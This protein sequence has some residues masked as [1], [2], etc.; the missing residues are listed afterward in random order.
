MIALLASFPAFAGTFSGVD[1]EITTGMGG[2]WARVHA[3]EEGWWFFQDAGGDYWAEDLDES[4]GGYDDHDRI[5]LT[6]V[7]NLQDTQ[8]E[9]CPDGGWLVI[10]S[11]TLAS[12]DDSAAA[13]RFAA[14]FTPMWDTVIVENDSTYR[15]NDM[16]PVCAEGAEGVIFA[17]GGN[18]SPTGEFLSLE[19]GSVADPVD[20]TL[21]AQGAS[22]AVRPSDGAYVAVDVTRPG[23]TEARVS[24]FDA[25]FSTVSSASVSLPGGSI[26][27][28]QRLQPLGEGWLLSYLGADGMT[29]M[30]DVWLAALDAE[31]NLVDSVQV[32]DSGKRDERPWFARKGGTVV[33]SYD[34]DTQPRLAAVTLEASAVPSGDDGILDTAD[35]PGD[36]GGDSSGNPPGDC[37]CSGG[38][39]APAGASAAWTPV[40]ALARDARWRRRGREIRAARIAR[41]APHPHA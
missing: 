39:G 20:V 30:G 17:G 23:T 24:V 16:V 32:S 4:L 8:V 11:Y 25:D 29:P 1:T 18:D 5:Q 38:G 27:W 41:P 12:F 35:S 34:R 37:G 10:G 31:F 40:F 7:G 28:T 19:G 22:F 33:V 3:V 13:W 6:A 36:S 14:D 15:H 21:N 9:R 26:A 2:T